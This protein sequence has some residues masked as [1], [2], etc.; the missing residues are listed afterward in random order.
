MHHAPALTMSAMVR[1]RTSRP[2]LSLL[3]ERIE[4]S[5]QDEIAVLQQLGATDG[6]VRRPFIYL[7]AW[8]GLAAGL[9][10]LG[11]VAIAAALLQPSLAS[12]V[13]SYGSRFQFTGPG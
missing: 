3:A 6:F 2:E 8:Y 4:V 12:L 7:G 13:G 10:A 9:A 5:Q 1:T 11:L